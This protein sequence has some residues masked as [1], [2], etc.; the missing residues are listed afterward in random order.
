M[1]NITIEELKII[2]PEKANATNRTKN[3]PQWKVQALDSDSLA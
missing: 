3:S 2:P 1:I